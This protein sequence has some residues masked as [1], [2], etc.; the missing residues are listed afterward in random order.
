MAALKKVF[1][2]FKG[3][4]ADPAYLNHK[5]DSG[6]NILGKKTA[7]AGLL[8]KEP[9]KAQRSHKIRNPPLSELPVNLQYN[10]ERCLAAEV[11]FSLLFVSRRSDF[12]PIS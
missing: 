4:A 2:L 3:P 1:C 8:K 12:C 9:C 11:E 6:D 5:A 10:G 7:S